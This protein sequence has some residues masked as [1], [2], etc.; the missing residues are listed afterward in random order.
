M[1]CKKCNSDLRDGINFCT[2]CGSKNTYEIKS[3]TNRD[4][5]L[6]KGLKIFLWVFFFPIMILCFVWNQ[7][8]ISKKFRIL[9]IILI[10]LFYFVMGLVQKNE[11]NMINETVI[12]TCYGEETL[13]IIKEIN[14]FDELRNIES[15]NQSCNSLEIEY[16]YDYEVEI[17]M[18]ENILQSI[19]IFDDDIYYYIYNLDKSYDIYDVETLE[20][21]EYA[22]SSLKAERENIE[23]SQAED[24]TS[25]SSENTEEKITIE[26]TII[27]D[28]EISIEELKDYYFDNG[29]GEGNKKY[30]GSSVK[31]TGYFMYYESGWG[32]KIVYLSNEAGSSKYKIACTSF[33][34]DSYDVF[35]GLEQGDKVVFSGIVDE[36]INEYSVYGIL[37]FDDCE[38]LN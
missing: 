7:K 10:L 37:S 18:D 23:S 17:L 20:V 34:D 31:T 11:Q 21:V 19:K 1:K 24:E 2:I 25:S 15:E 30:F 28:Y 26:K 35:I 32:Y 14:L 22:N 16:G 3:E 38:I 13:E 29:E 8:K 33:I 12:L 6:K 27:Y 9:I 4:F 36:L 5:G